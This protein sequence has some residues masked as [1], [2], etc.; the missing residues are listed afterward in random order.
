MINPTIESL[1]ISTF[2]SCFN[3]FDWKLGYVL[4]MELWKF[5]FKFYVYQTITPFMHSVLMYRLIGYRATVD[6]L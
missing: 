6:V 2:I 5:R 1:R 3:N 4:Y